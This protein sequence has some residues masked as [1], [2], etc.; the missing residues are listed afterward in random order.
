MT[1]LSKL[2]ED[3]L[4]DLA[5]DPHELWELYTFVR[6]HHPAAPEADVQ[7]L[8]HELLTTWVNRGWLKAATSR[9]EVRRLTGEQ[10]LAEVSKLGQAAADPK[11][12]TIVLILTDRAA[13]DEGWLKTR[14]NAEFR[15]HNT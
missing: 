14:N 3:F 1:K 13:E 9:R 12:G 5:K 15:G 2:E 11:K 4:G 7:R 10:L 8:G 6:H